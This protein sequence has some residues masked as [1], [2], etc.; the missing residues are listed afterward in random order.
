MRQ[1]K[2]ILIAIATPIILLY[3][4]NERFDDIKTVATE[5]RIVVESFIS[6]IDSFSVRLTRTTDFPSADDVPTI[7]DAT[8]MI[9]DDLD[10]T[11]SLTETFVGSGIYQSNDTGVVGRSY[12]LSIT[13][14]SVTY[15]SPFVLMLPV[16]T[17]DELFIRQDFDDY[18]GEYFAFACVQDEKDTRDFYIWFYDTY[19]K[20]GAGGIDE[21]KTI[22]NYDVIDDLLFNG[23]ST[24]DD[25]SLFA[26]VNDEPF[27]SV[28]TFL[29]MQ[30][31]HV[32]EDA[33]DYWNQV[34]IQTQFVGGPFDVPPSPIIGN[35]RNVEDQNDYTLGYFMVGGKDIDTVIVPEI[36]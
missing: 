13:V 6:N 7:S 1:V 27:E 16:A 18:D 31:Y 33:A 15:Q 3:A 22:V 4:C 32:D 35:V 24:C 25:D 19:K 2:Y 29:V 20:D 28:D 9:I 21:S 36:E 30:Q 23:I 10:D 5:D 17:I 26:E 12:Q 8:V 11:V 34:L 14:D